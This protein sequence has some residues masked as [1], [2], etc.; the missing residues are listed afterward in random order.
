MTVEI[1]GSDFD[2]ITF[3]CYGT[4]I[5]WEAGLSRYLQPLLG[6]HDCHVV[7]SFLFDFY[8]RTEAALQAGPYRRYRQILEAVL[9]ALGERL[10]F[11]PS[12]QALADFPQSI[13][14]WLPFPD[15]VPALQALAGRYQLGVISNID[16]DLFELTR[17]RLGVD[18]KHVVTAA[19]VGAYKPDPRPFATA[20]ARFG[21]PKQRIL[22]VAQSLYHDIAPASALGLNTVWIDRHDGH[23]SGA[24]PSADATPTW[25]LRNLSELAEALA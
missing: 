23:G 24:T 18:F 6:A 17:P 1:D 9:A 3:D 20:I 12:A 25:K 11:R 7:E 21:V 16:D 5:D 2:A 19:Q 15:T 22:H 14:D 13:A 10:G 4:L 8:G